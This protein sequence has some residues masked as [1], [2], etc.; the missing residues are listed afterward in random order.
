MVES[1]LHLHYFRR[2]FRSP[3]RASSHTVLHFL[4]SKISILFSGSPWPTLSRSTQ[5]QEAFN[6]AVILPIILCVLIGIFFINL[7][8]E[9]QRNALDANARLIFGV[10]IFI[11]CLILNVCQLIISNLEFQFQIISLM[12]IRRLKVTKTT[13]IVSLLYANFTQY[14]SRSTRERSCA[15]FLNTNQPHFIIK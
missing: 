3:R 11:A 13:S 4:Y 15:D 2:S 7:I 10:A 5:L 14:F 9:I 1:S 12:I 8:K 6:S